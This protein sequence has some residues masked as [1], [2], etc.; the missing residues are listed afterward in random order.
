MSPRQQ[1]IHFLK[2]LLALYDSRNLVISDT[3]FCL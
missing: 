1:N 2:I 3:Q